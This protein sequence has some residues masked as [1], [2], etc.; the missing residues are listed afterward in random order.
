MKQIR[1]NGSFFQRCGIQSHSYT[2][3]FP[4]IK[5]KDSGFGLL[6]LCLSLPKLCS[7]ILEPSG[8]LIGLFQGA[9][10]NFNSHLMYLNLKSIWAKSEYRT[11]EYWNG[12]LSVPL[13]QPSFVWDF[14]RCI[15]SCLGIPSRCIESCLG[16]PFVDLLL[17]YIFLFK[18]EGL[19]QVSSTWT[20]F[21]RDRPYFLTQLSVT[22]RHH[23]Y[24]GYA[25]ARIYAPNLCASSNSPFMI[26]RWPS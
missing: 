25:T 24:P 10:C 1:S 23:L 9:P 8:F 5:Q 12:W 21:S 6:E 17:C 3:T 19:K 13:Q 2:C 18:K 15:E 22:A 11:R 4:R 26:L 16:I 14:S 7:R 20:S